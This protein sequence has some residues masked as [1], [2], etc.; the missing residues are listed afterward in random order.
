MEL[1]FGR[2]TDILRKALLQEAIRTAEGK[3]STVDPNAVSSFLLH[4]PAQQARM[5]HTDELL[6]ETY[7]NAMVATQDTA[8]MRTLTST[9][10][11]SL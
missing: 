6:W 9:F 8:E 2:P 7:H 4:P 3:Y 11:A 10:I 5:S 1:N